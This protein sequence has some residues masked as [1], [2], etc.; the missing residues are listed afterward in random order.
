MNATSARPRLRYEEIAEHIEL[1][2]LSGRRPRV[3]ICRQNAI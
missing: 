2:V 3:Q 1:M